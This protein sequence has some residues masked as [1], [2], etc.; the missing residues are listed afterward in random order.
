MFAS[1][2]LLL[3]VDDGERRFSLTD[4]VI[5]IFIQMVEKKID[6]I[7]IDPLGDSAIAFFQFH[8]TGKLKGGEGLYRPSGRVTMSFLH[9]QVGWRA[10]HYHES[11][12]AAQAAEQINKMRTLAQEKGSQR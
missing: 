3:L 6:G 8:S 9:T 7:K 5:R 12:L 10:I 2:F 11:A 4:I 1:H